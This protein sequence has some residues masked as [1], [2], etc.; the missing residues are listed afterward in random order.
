MVGYV[1]KSEENL[2][3]IVFHCVPLCSKNKTHTLATDLVKR[4]RLK[5]LKEGAD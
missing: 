5:R 2:Q 1:I 4:G 3:T